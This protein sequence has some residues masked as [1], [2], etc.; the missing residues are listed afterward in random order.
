MTVMARRSGKWLNVEVHPPGSPRTLFRIG[1]DAARGPRAHAAADR[2]M[3][4][5][6]AAR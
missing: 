5:G 1:R 4:G 3:M 6:A 2:V